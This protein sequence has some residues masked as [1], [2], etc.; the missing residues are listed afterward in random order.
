MTADSQKL[1]A[2]YCSPGMKRR[3][4]VWFLRCGLADGS[5][6][7]W[8]RYL[9]LNPGKKGC[10]TEAAG[11][12]VQMWATWFPRSGKPQTFIQGYALQQAALSGRGAAPFFLRVAEC[13]IEH[14][15]CWGNIAV[16]GHR[17]AWQLR[18]H[19]DF[20]VVLSNKGWIGFCN[21][22]HSNAVFSGEIHF[23]GQHFFGEPL[24]F[25]VQGHNSGYRHRT[26]WRWM[27]AYFGDGA[28]GASTVEALVYDMPLGM[29]FRNVVWWHGKKAVTLRG[30]AEKEIVNERDALRWS[31]RGRAA[32]GSTVEVLAEAQSPETHHL[33][34]TKTDCSGTFPV[35]NASLARAQVRFGTNLSQTL[36]TGTGA[37]LEMGG[38]E[39]SAKR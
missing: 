28:E 4:E 31:F 38:T 23:D 13:G 21:S 1:N 34:Y 33:P 18:C 16:D 9:L 24:A 7:W 27:H 12:P 11:M 6:A 25:G 5:G 10:A 35:A 30:I 22:P 8:F 19:S 37:V 20:G 29:V 26:Y 15:T 32:D 3:Y 36:E 14:G 17:I 2:V 39:P